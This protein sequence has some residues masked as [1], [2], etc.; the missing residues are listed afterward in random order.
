MEELQRLPAGMEEQ[1][2]EQGG[3]SC[4]SLFERGGRIYF[5]AAGA[6]VACQMSCREGEVTVD[7]PCDLVLGFEPDDSFLV[8]L[9]TRERHRGHGLARKLIDYVSADLAA[10]G[11]R[12][13]FAHIRATNHASLAAFRHA[14]WKLC[15]RIITTTS[16]RFI[17]APGCRR[18]RVRIRELTAA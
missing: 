18:A 6:E 10:R 17:A 12:R 11:Q 13:C 14:G 7:S 9:Y 8:Y 5:F 4:R 1:L 15:G 3:L 2:D 16:K